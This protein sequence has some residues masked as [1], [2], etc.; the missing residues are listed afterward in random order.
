LQ[1]VVSVTVAVVLTRRAVESLD[2]WVDECRQPSLVSPQNDEAINRNF[3]AG[4]AGCFSSRM[5]LGAV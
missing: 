2:D 4:Q 3:L 1:I 5:R